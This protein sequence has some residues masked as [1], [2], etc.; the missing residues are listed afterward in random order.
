MPR[1]QLRGRRDD[2]HDEAGG[3]ESNG[4]DGMLLEW[5]TRFGTEGLERELLRRMFPEGGSAVSP[6]GT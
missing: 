3:L 5:V 6:A 2:R 4:G 1:K